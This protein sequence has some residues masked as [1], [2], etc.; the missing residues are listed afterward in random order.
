MVGE[1][2]EKTWQDE[3]LL[4]RLSQPEACLRAYE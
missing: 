2:E 3:E 1:V 4:I